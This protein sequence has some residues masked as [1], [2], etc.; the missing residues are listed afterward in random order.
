MTFYLQDTH[1]WSS[2]AAGAAFLPMIGAITV[3]SIAGAPA[4]MHRF[5]SRVP[6]AGGSLLGAGGLFWLST[7]SVTSSYAGTVLPALIVLG[8]GMG[9]IFGAGFN[10]AT[11][12][13]RPD[14]AGVASAL[15]NA[16]QQM[17]GAL[18]AAL[19]SSIALQATS[20]PDGLRVAAV[21][22]YDRAFLVAA[23]VFLATA[24]ATASLIPRRE[25]PRPGT[26]PAASH[27][28]L[29]SHY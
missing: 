14:D 22:G 2:L 25:R 17:A 28:P 18:G 23:F 10:S 21:A 4:L 19:L 3:T 16:G 11:A 12:G 9:L 6:I 26:E 29:V 1:L 24:T 20:S 8:L 13:V 5:G 27:S 7:L 15:A